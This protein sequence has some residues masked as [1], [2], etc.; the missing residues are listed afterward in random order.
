ME[1][2][3]TGRTTNL[4]LNFAKQAIYNAG[5]PTVILD[6]WDSPAAHRNLARM[7][8]DILAVLHVSCIRHNNI[9]TVEPRK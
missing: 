5:K 9:I 4:A 6:H 3:G 2:K 7:V 1:L 8:E